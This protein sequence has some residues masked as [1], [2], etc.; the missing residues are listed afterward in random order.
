MYD[1]LI[2]YH[3]MVS[4][5]DN[6]EVRFAHYERVRDFNEAYYAIYRMADNSWFGSLVASDWNETMSP[7]EFYF[8]GVDYG[9]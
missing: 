2:I 1:E 5:C 3:E 8:H 9:D 7:L 6:E 4:E